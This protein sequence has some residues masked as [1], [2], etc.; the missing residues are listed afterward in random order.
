MLI[1]D[2]VARL[3]EVASLGKR[4]EGAADLAAMVKADKL[5]AVTPHTYV[6]PLGLRPRSEGDAATGAFTQA[7]D[8]VVGVILIVR[9]SCDA[10]GAKSL[11]TIQQLISDV[12]AALGGFDPAE[13]IGVLRLQ[14]GELVSLNAGAVI[15]QLDF[16]ILTQLRNLA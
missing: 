10:T 4:V 13:A 2:V 15:Y 7:I 5:P 14:R 1:D 3:K 12:L 16:A 6:V 11:G 8:E 9:A